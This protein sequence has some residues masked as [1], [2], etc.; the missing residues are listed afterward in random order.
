MSTPSP[1]MIIGAIVVIVV[2][3]LLLRPSPTPTQYVPRKRGI[4]F[5]EAVLLLLAIGMT[6]YWLPWLFAHLPLGNTHVQVM[7]TAHPTPT[8]VKG[9]RAYYIAYARSAATSAGIDPGIFVRQIDEES[10]W[11]PNAISP[12]GAIGI[13]QFMLQTA[14]SLG[15]NPYNPEQSLTGAAK[16]MASY[17]KLFHGSYAMALAAYNAGTGRVLSAIVQAQKY[18]GSWDRYLSDETQHYIHVILGY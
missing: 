3:L 15:I 2:L 7:T 12:A 4:G 8:P 18:G 9:T 13:A 16:L 1:L 14:K 5:L 11:N 6:I 10:A 17:V